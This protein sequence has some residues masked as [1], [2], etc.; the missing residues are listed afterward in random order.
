MAKKDKDRGWA[1]AAASLEAR[2]A[3]IEAAI[4]AAGGALP[5]D[6]DP[7]PEGRVRISVRGGAAEGPGDWRHEAPVATLAAAE[8][9]AAAPRL[10]ALG[11]PVRLAILRAVAEGA[12]EAAALQQAA[13]AA[14]P[15][16]PA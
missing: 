10:A 11:H 9:Q 4:A 8:W 15:T 1:E 2:L 16:T 13:G 5:R 14:T 7:G 3:R 12:S 6:P